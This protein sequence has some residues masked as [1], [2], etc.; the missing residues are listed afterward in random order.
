[1]LNIVY[2]CKLT[3]MQYNSLITAIPQLWH[4][5]LAALGPCRAIEYKNKAQDLCNIQ[6]KLVSKTVYLEM[7]KPTCDNLDLH[8]KWLPY[9]DNN[10]G[11]IDQE[12]T[13]WFLHLNV[14]SIDNHP[15]PCMYK[16]GI[17]RVQGCHTPILTK[18]TSSYITS[19]ICIHE[20]AR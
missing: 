18:G 4:R 12:S 15:R 20:L 13:N 14:I 8:T 7:I 16:V 2:D 6:R 10:A 9:L 11:N 17:V 19:V 1:M 5:K 3:V